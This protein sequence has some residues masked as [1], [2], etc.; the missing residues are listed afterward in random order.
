ML[1]E[2]LN[3]I[4]IQGRAFDLFQNYLL[5]RH[6]LVRLGSKYSREI[7]VNHRVS[8]GTV[9]GPL[10]FNL[11]VNE[12]TQVKMKHKIFQFFDDTI[13]V[14]VHKKYTNAEEEI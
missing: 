6:Q 12:I 4:G 9:L 14:C 5:D 2:R 3:S 1:L 10:L 7:K 8:Q 13:I 11:Y